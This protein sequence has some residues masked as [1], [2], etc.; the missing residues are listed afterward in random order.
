[1]LGTRANSI[2]QSLDTLKQQQ[3]RSGLS[4]RADIVSTQQRMEYQLDQAEGALTAG[5]PSKAKKSLESAER[6]IEKL[7]KFLGH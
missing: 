3:A 6:E 5:D 2:R 1:M 7:E 4:L